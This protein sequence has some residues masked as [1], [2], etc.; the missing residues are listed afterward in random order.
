MSKILKV[1]DEV[2]W[3]GSFGNDAPKK[4]RVE[5]IEVCPSGSKYGDQVEEVEWSKCGRNVVVDLD[6]GTWAYGTQ[7]KPI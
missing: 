5:G 7:I 3:R 6:N 1:G 2:M 4:A